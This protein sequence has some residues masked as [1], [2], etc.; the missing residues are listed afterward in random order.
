MAPNTKPD[1]CIN[2]PNRTL[3]ISSSKPDQNSKLAR[4]EM[5]NASNSKPDQVIK[6]VESEAR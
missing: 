6:M 4:P 5:I 2:V 3:N 1:Q